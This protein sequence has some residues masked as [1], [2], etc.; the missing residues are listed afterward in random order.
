MPNGSDDGRRTRIR[1]LPGLGPA[2]E[3]MLAEIGITSIEQ[4]FAV[5]VYDIYASLHAR[6]NA[7][8]N[9]LYALIGAKENVA[10]TDIARTRRAEILFQLDNLGLAPD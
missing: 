4:L 9:F 8:L 10:W 1:D 2:S 5:D 6:G 3:K 7:N